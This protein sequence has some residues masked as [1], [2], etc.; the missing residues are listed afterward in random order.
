MGAFAWSLAATSNLVL[1]Q[2]AMAAYSIDIPAGSLAQSLRALA[3]LAGVS[4]G[5]GGRLPSIKTKPV[6]GARNAAE[7]LA[8]MLE[9]TGYRA[10]ATGPSS[11]RIESGLRSR[12][13]PAP[14]PRDESIETANIVV[15]AL[16]R[17]APLF[18]LPATI[19][20]IRQVDLHTAS[21]I[22]GDD[23]LDRELPSMSA[24]DLGAGRNRLFL[25]GIGDGPLGG[26]N[27]GS[28]AILMDEARVT[29]DAP[30]P[31]WALVD[32]DRV[33]VLE[34]PQG[35]LYGTGAIGGIV[36][37]VTRQPDLTEA[38]F[39][40]TAAVAITRDGD[41]TNSQSL[42]LNLPTAN[43]K[44]AARAVAY[45]VDRAGW[46]DNVGGL[47]D[48]NR[49]RLLGGRFGLKIAAGEWTVDLSAGIQSRGADDSQY[50]DGD[51]GPLNRTARLSEPGD[52]DASVAMMTVT[53]PVA[54]LELTSISS[55]SKQEA[56]ARYDATP[57]ADLLGTSGPTKVTDDRRYTVFDQ[58]VRLRNPTPKSFGWIAGASLIKA[59]SD[60]YISAEGTANHVGLL[61][62]NRSVTETA[63]FGEA[64]FK[65]SPKLTI[66]AGGR[67]FSS[68]IE[69]EGSYEGG[70]TVE[71]KSNIRGAASVAVS[72]LVA[73]GS[74]IFLRASTAY[75]PGG[76][77]I[78]PEATQTEYEADE[79][80]SIELGTHVTIDETLALNASTFATQ[81]KHV[82][83][84][85][86]L[87]NGLV[88]TRNAGDAVN[89]GIEGKLT[90]RPSATTTVDLGFLLQSSKLQNEERG[91]AIDDTRLPVVPQVAARLKLAQGFKFA[92]WQGHATA[93]VD[94]IGATH[95]SFDPTLDRRTR[96]HA[97]IDASVDLSKGEW[98]IGLAADNLGNSAANTFAFGNPYRVR[99]QEQRTPERPRT[100]GMTVSRAF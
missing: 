73:H 75:R 53:G 85:E 92:G 99:N 66:G 26:F 77:N 13:E 50:V 70:D 65:I 100:I 15:T 42:I 10:I 5:S 23:I 71:G 88:A 48:S 69:D 16:K 51:L 1:P 97:T 40:A 2:S 19:G 49:E 28:V 17:G 76:I 22:A 39:S 52:L 55:L 95:L 54:G 57:L 87:A 89:F 21:G 14:T 91:A 78:Q 90:W 29:Y 11:F 8:Q 32:I 20:I 31:D 27:Q 24:S 68:H 41:M 6:R 80:A 84:D 98:T 81:W 94:F 12:K 9:G 36:K 86:L 83:A 96:G 18:S 44:V 60:V 59:S 72:W 34:G 37:V 4:V 58:E 43:G 3:S 38:S 62:F 47:G 74:T 46:I 79:L 45:R 63:L 33:E 35:P 61:T 30:D 7:A 82:Q 25:R 93:G 67:L 56:V 64:S